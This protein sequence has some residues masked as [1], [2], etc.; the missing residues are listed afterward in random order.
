MPLVPPQDWGQYMP[1][2]MTAT[3]Y[4][5]EQYEQ[6]QAQLQHADAGWDQVWDSAFNQHN[7]ASS[8]MAKWANHPGDM[9]EDERQDFADGTYNYENFVPEEY[10]N[11]PRFMQ[12]FARYATSPRNAQWVIDNQNRN[13]KEREMLDQ[14]LW[15]GMAA[16]LIAGA[17][18]PETIP[19]YIVPAGLALKGSSMAGR[20]TLSRALT[21][22]AGIAA[23]TVGLGETALYQMQPT[24]TVEESIYAV[25]ASVL[26]SDILVAGAWSL[27]GMQR[28]IK[29][30]EEDM[31]RIDSNPAVSTAGAM[32]ARIPLPEELTERAAANVDAKIQKGLI[33][34]EARAEAIKLEEKAMEETLSQVRHPRI[35][36]VLG[37]ASP[38]VRLATARMHSARELAAQLVDDPLSRIR[39]TYGQSLGPSVE[40]EIDRMV[41]SLG[42]TVYDTMTKNYKVYKDWTKQNQLKAL[43]IDEFADQVG[44]AMRVSDKAD[45][46]MIARTASELR[47][48]VNKP[49]EDRLLKAGLLD[50]K[51]EG[52]EDLRMQDLLDINDEL[53]PYRPEGFEPPIREETVG[54]L[55]KE[56]GTPKANFIKE[57]D[58]DY[59]DKLIET[60]KLRE[61]AD[62]V[63]GDESYFHRT[64]DRAAIDER[65]D[66]FE[67]RL[68]GILQE[69]ADRRLYKA[70]QRAEEKLTE[71]ID[72]I[73]TRAA[74]DEMAPDD[75]TA[76][77]E[78]GRKNA[79]PY[80]ERVAQAEAKKEQIDI[81]QGQLIETRKRYRTALARERIDFDEVGKLFDR[82]EKIQT[83]LR[84]SRQLHRVSIEQ[85][86]AELEDD[87]ANIRA[88]N[89]I[90]REDVLPDELTQ[91]AREIKNAIMGQEYRPGYRPKSFTA[92]P[93]KNR[94]FYIPSN[95]AQEFLVNNA[96]TVWGDYFQQVL[97]NLIMKEKLGSVDIVDDMARI[98]NDYDDA[99]EAAKTV[100]QKQS[101]NRE[102]AR[103]QRDL[104]A[105][106]ESLHNRYKV[107]DDP[108]SFFSKAAQRLREFN[109]MTLLGMMT[110]S[111]IPDVGHII[112]RHGLRSFS[113]GLVQVAKQSRGMKLNMRHMKSFGLAADLTN[114]G[115]AQ[116]MGMIDN[117]YG[118]MTNGDRVMQKATSTFT[119]LTGMAHWN[120]GWK[121]FTGFIYSNDM[122]TDAVNMASG[123][124]GAKKTAA[125]ARAG[126]SADD[127]KAIAKELK[128]QKEP[129]VDG[130]W[131]ASPDEWADQALA[132]RYKNAIHKEVDTTIVTPGKGDLPLASRN[133]VGRLIFQ[134]KSFAMSANNRVLLATLDD[135]SAQKVIGILSMVALGGVAQISRDFLRGRETKLDTDDDLK[136]FIDNALD[137]SGLLAY[138]GDVNGMIEKASRGKAHI[139]PKLADEPLDRY[140]SRNLLGS[141][142]GPSA[143]RVSDVGQITGAISA[144]DW[145]ETDARAMRRLLL[146]NNLFWTNRVFNKLEEAMGGKAY[147]PTGAEL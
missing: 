143:G 54:G 39:H 43:S 3:Y 119:K 107:P 57:L 114:N 117:N 94:T 140:A 115:R 1:R 71:V 41:N 8:Y 118:L 87:L 100:R 74:R 112:M 147:S 130:L 122:L 129:K 50:S 85:R 92:G 62:K 142:L 64:W 61:V 91:A 45:I 34:P 95:K 123:R 49:L 31:L 128:A 63:A 78:R 13:V 56:D 102:R 124:L 70:E 10:K 11:D 89:K 98:L 38:S 80:H 88:E 53:Y 120:A 33:E 113:K 2:D 133:E 110:I 23:G 137:R 65:P 14:N 66:V 18:S 116:R 36:K 19:A 145:R 9:T 21:Y 121:Q 105:M 48:K 79:R 30:T 22:E 108:T 77:M 111:A 127:M 131:V 58:Q 7:V 60:G 5:P 135:M 55:F 141:I 90:Y 126:I 59:I 72:E 32:E 47:Q 75:V 24:R 83:S 96:E 44:I 17:T 101:L 27:R 86:M 26:L 109:F 20:L 16:T 29:E 136:R 4:S 42:Q 46:E 15:S 37:F 106:V 82:M 12:E 97:P 84:S 76:M 99:I 146:L 144:G 6:E 69:E 68:R 138:W 134:F 103:V 104:R 93:L 28:A 125:Y 25:G 35:M 52:V 73:H 67:A 51:I 139:V 40:I 132:T 81:L